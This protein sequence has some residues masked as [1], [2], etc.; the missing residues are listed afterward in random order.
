MITLVGGDLYQWDTGRMVQVESNVGVVSHEVHFSTDN[1]DFAYVVKTY[2]EGNYT[3]C[4]IPDIILQTDARLYCYEV[5]EN[6]DG[7][8]TTSMAKFKVKKRNRPDDYV[9]T[10]AEIL[11]YEELKTAINDLEDKI[12]V[13][14]SDLKN[15]S[16]FLTTENDV[17][18]GRKADT[19]IGEHSVAMGNEVE[20]SGKF[21][22]ATGNNTTASGESSHATGQ[23]SVASGPISSVEGFGSKATREYSHAEGYRTLASGIAAHAEGGWFNDDYP[24]EAKGDYS[25]AEGYGVQTLNSY[26]HGEGFKTKTTGVAGHSEGA[27]SEAAGMGSHAEGATTKAS[28]DYSHAEGSSSKAENEAA[29]AEGYQTTASGYGS[30]SEGYNSEA[31]GMGSHAENWSKA[32]GQMSHSEGNNTIAAGKNQHVQGKY[33]VEDTEN[34]YAHIIGGGTSDAERKNIHT[35]DWEGNAVYE[36]TVEADGVILRS[37]TEGSAKRFLLKIDDS[38]ELQI[39]ELS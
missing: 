20:A 29:H 26:G 34:K 27:M 35:V 23:E 16:Y 9:Y 32:K 24:L 15:D 37:A 25:H 36:G 6:T 38:G 11:R 39:S 5:C 30:H 3:Y 10:K 21:S 17:S 14:T 33:N 19:E 18:F 2:S 4:R 13:N 8:E 12:P 7:E 1:L 31:S 22:F 28:G